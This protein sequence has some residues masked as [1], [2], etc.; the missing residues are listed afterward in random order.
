[1]KNPPRLLFSELS[2]RVYVVTRYT[3]REHPTKSGTG[4]IVAHT[5]YDVTA[6]FDEIGSKRKNYRARERRGP[7]QT[8]LDGKLVKKERS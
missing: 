7:I 1:M 6:D 4:V 2:G 3:V 8:T 5:K